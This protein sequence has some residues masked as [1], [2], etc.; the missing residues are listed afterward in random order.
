[1]TI[2]H[3]FDCNGA[4]WAFII[5]PYSSQSVLDGT[6]QFGCPDTLAFAASESPL[7][8][9]FFVVKLSRFLALRSH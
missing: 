5:V 7:D 8:N 6:S 2:K 1:M 9:C 4:E 3:F